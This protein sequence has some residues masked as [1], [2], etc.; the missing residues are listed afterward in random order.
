MRGFV[1][2]GL[3][4]LAVG[5]GEANGVGSAAPVTP[6]PLLTMDADRLWIL[7]WARGD[8]APGCGKFYANPSDPRHADQALPCA[9]WERSALEM[10]RAND[11]A[12]IEI[13]H[14]RDPQFWGWYY[15][16][17]A[18]IAR[19]SAE[20]LKAADSATGAGRRRRLS[21]DPYERVTLLEA[22]TMAEVG[23]RVP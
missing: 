13:E 23:I 14:L 18:E 19:C 6:S 1:A 11:L 9:R 8:M 17:A 16:K 7:L 5:C 20:G 15:Q 10:L 4:L 22:K 12:G 2:L 21:C 3:T